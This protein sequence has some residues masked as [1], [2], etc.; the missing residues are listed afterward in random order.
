[1]R[2]A[3]VTGGAKRIGRAIVQRLAK[4]GYAVAIHC[5]RSRADAEKLKHEI[6]ARAGRAE[7]I[8]AD[9][10]DGDAVGAIVHQARLALGPL[11]LLVNNA[12]V[13]EPDDVQ[14]LEQ[15]IWDHQFNVNLRAPVLLSCDFA[16]QLPV[17]CEGTVVNVLDQ[18]V[19]RPTPR[20]FSYTLSK[21]ALFSA[22]Q[23]MAQALA[24][25]IRVN[26]VGPGPTLQSRWQSEDEFVRQAESLPLEHGALPDEIADA[27]L[28]LTNARSITGQ[29]LAVDGGQHLAWQR[30]QYHRLAAE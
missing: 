24:P 1:M 8:E 5:H 25:R 4:E 3:L 16:N 21:C 22:T 23:T 10:A 19:L 26:A 14:T 27:V 6:E 18:R 29:M 13:Y 12:S 28:F 20:F 7:I 30:D 11:T 15:S 17:G 2:T 9:L